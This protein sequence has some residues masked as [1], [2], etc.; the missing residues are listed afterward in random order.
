[1]YLC[2]DETLL[3]LILSDFANKNQANSRRFDIRNLV[4]AII[5]DVVNILAIKQN[6]VS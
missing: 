3:K 2:H 4:E 6:L 5:Q 1:M